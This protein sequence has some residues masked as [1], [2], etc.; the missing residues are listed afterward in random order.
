[1]KRWGALVAVLTL[2]IV[3]GAAAKISVDRQRVKALE[4]KFDQRI[5]AFS[6]DDPFY[7]LGNARGVYLEG[8]GVVFTAELNL[9]AAA[10]ITPFRPSFT[11]EQIEKLRQKK[12]A[13]LKPLREM[14]RFTMEDSATSLKSIPATERVAVG[15][16]LFYYSW[17]DTRGLPS[18]VLMQTERQNL[19][20]FESG[21]INVSQ[22]NSAIRIQEF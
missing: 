4:R 13:R 9:V 1:M 10:V 11:P 2:A 7:L 14:M 17:E 21:R 18:Q 6:I 3:T 8:Y 15:V 16:S 5:E 22:L 19:L 12:L 20:D